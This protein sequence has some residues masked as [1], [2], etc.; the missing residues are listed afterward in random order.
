[1]KI[2]NRYNWPAWLLLLSG[3]CAAL[4]LGLTG[5][6]P[7]EMVWIQIAIVCLGTASLIVGLVALAVWA[8]QALIDWVKSSTTRNSR[9]VRVIITV[10]VV[11][12]TAP[13]VIYYVLMPA[14]ALPV[15]VIQALL[16]Q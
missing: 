10:A 11:I 3:I 9:T 13:L 1:M 7:Q 4:F 8:V 12:L 2:I 15:I 16:N 5:I 6:V 14:I